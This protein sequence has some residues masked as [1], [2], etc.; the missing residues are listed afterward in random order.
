MRRVRKIDTARRRNKKNLSITQA[1]ER[2]S[3]KE[4]DEA[5]QQSADTRSTLRHRTELSFLLLQSLHLHVL[6]P[7]TG[8]KEGS[9]LREN[10][11]KQVESRPTFFSLSSSLTVLTKLC[12]TGRNQEARA[13]EKNEEKHP[14]LPAFFLPSPASPRKAR[15]RLHGSRKLKKSALPNVTQ[16][17]L[18]TRHL[19]ALPLPCLRLRSAVHVCQ[20]RLNKNSTFS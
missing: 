17:R 13:K 2:C 6:E 8:R 5:R 11:R 14:H 12:R 9:E 3:H 16:R 10:E 15:L 1:P 4:R 19:S 7:A 20:L 18:D